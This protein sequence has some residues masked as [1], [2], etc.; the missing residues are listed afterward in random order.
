MI[1]R[2]VRIVAGNLYPLHFVCRGFGF[3][4]FR[5]TQSVFR[6]LN[7]DKPHV[8]DSKKVSGPGHPSPM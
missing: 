4:T 7:A 3:V 5:D 1:G 6:A 8:L 2:N